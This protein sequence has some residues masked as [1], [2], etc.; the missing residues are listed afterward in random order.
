MQLARKLALIS[1]ASGALALAPPALASTQPAAGSF[2]EG[3]ET[4]TSEH[5]AGGNLVLELTRDV[6]FSGT[7]TGIGQAAER[8]VIHSD[9]STNV[10]IAIAFAGLACGQPATLEFLL[11]AQGQL[12]E[13]FENG[14][15]AGAY[16]T[17]DSGQTPSRTLRG[18]GEIDG[19]AGV[20]GSYA[21]QIH[22]E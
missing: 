8:I 15:V 19:I 12:D 20:G 11:A 14:T 5:V 17:T 21:G 7:Y 6:T 13:N 16:T 1:G 2:I 3:P 10:H 18:N 4:V 22:C 9:G